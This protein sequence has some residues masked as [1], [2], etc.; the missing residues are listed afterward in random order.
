MPQAENVPSQVTRALMSNS[1]PLGWI[2]RVSSWSAGKRRPRMASPKSTPAQRAATQGWRLPRA[3]MK[4]PATEAFFVQSQ[5]IV[6]SRKP[7]SL[8]TPL[9]RCRPIFVPLASASTRISTERNGDCMSVKSWSKTRPRTSLCWSPQ[10]LFTS[11]VAYGRC[12][13]TQSFQRL[14]HQSPSNRSSAEGWSSPRRRKAKGPPGSREQSASPATLA[15]WL[16]RSS[17]A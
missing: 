11:M 17:S 10:W 7:S 2:S 8:P 15:R 5:V 6:P 16:S 4:G 14:I 3:W 9:R 13:A 1:T 12:F